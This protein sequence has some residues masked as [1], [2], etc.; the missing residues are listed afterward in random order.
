[1]GT[2]TVLCLFKIFAS[3][4]NWCGW[5]T[6]WSLV[7]PVIMSKQGEVFSPYFM[8]IQLEITN[9]RSTMH[10]FCPRPSVLLVVLSEVLL[11]LFVGYIFKMSWK[12]SVDS[13]HVAP[14]KRIYIT[15]PDINFFVI[16]KTEFCANIVQN[17]VLIHVSIF[18]L[19]R[20]KKKDTGRWYM[21]FS[22]LLV[23][24]VI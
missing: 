23:D 7:S 22:L 13:Y 8:S 15:A 17:T 16:F 5:S 11:L 2:W 19:F 4:A 21:S 9:P 18:F 3:V 20:D 14:L 6:M 10:S 1:M 24:R 12:T